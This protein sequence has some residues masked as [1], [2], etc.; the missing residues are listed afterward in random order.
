MSFDEL[1]TA[2]RTGAGAYVADIPDGWQ[3]GRGAFGGLSLGIMVRALEDTAGPERPLRTVSAQLLAPVLPGEVTLAVEKLREGNAVSTLRITMT[4]NG[5]VVAH[6]VGVHGGARPSG[7]SWQRVE[8]PSPLPWR[9]LTPMTG[10][11]PPAP[12]FTQ[13]FE[14]RTVASLPF[15]GGTAT[16]DGWVRPRAAASRRDA[17]WVAAV[18]DAWWPVVVVEMT[19]PRPIGTITFGLQ[20][21]GVE[22]DD[23]PLRY[24]ATAPAAA[25][26][27]ITEL[28][29]LWTEDGRLVAMNQQVIAVIK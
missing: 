10:P 15:M 2:R 1:L 9:E 25:D 21:F 16:I 3:Q 22:P 6:G 8:P 19:T 17:A 12:V 26:G 14:V 13:H 20:L 4:Q 29:E 28:S 23:A 18:A 7:P 5:E 27:Y 11:S 24:R